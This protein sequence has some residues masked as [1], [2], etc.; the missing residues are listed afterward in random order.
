VKLVTVTMTL[1]TTLI[2]FGV[3]VYIPRKVYNP[4]PHS[5]ISWAENGQRPSA[6]VCK[7]PHD[8]LDDEGILVFVSLRRARHTT[9]LSRTCLLSTLPR[10]SCQRKKLA[11]PVLAKYKLLG[12]S[13]FVSSGTKRQGRASAVD[14]VQPVNTVPRC[15]LR[16]GLTDCDAGN[17]EAPSAQAS[18]V[19]SARGVLTPCLDY[20][21]Q[22]PQRSFKM[23][24]AREVQ[25]RVLGTENSLHLVKWTS[26]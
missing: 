12:L 1:S 9:I 18:K 6:Q 11:M 21:A 2:P 3:G 23:F 22:W 25:A 5:A 4:A 19:Q 17:K 14:G 8:V 26:A 16:V 20:D 7:H 13:A 24:F 10:S 15:G